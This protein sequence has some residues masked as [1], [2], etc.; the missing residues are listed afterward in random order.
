MSNFDINAIINQAAA[1]SIDL[2]EASS[3]GGGGYE[4]AAEGI[5]IPVLVGY[6][7]LGRRLKKGFQGAPDKKV[8]QAKWIFEIHGTNRVTT[9]D[10]GVKSVKRVTIKTWLPEPGKQASD[11]SGFYKLFS[12]LNYDKDPAIKIPAQLIGR[13]MLGTIEHYEFESN[14]EKVKMAS[15]GGAKDGFLL[16]PPRTPI[17][18]E[19]TGVPTGEYRVI[20]CPEIIGD[21][22]VFLWDYANKAMWD[23]L[24]IE[25][26]YEAVEAKDG[27]P[28]RPAK[29]KNVIQQELRQ[30]LDWEGSPIATILASAGVELDVTEIEQA[31]SNAPAG[32]AAAA[33]DPLAGML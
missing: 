6:L 5:C 30:A 8:R 3:G 33:A 16:S 28:A 25:G 29:S 2:S 4:P 13:H 23:S 22:K 19:L 7:E 27:K 11:K 24:F 32:S 26:E 9:N 14:G 12:A 20:P 15:L 18:D 21:R 17:I 10:E 31:S 1:E